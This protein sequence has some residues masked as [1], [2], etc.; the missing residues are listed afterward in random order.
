MSAGDASKS[1]RL[2]SR[3][4]RAISDGIRSFTVEKAFSVLIVKIDH[5]ANT[6]KYFANR[7]DR[8]S[9]SADDPD[10]LAE[11]MLKMCGVITT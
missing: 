3:I 9:V 11:R 2:I 6:G 8:V 4:S 5:D 1:A 10:Q 7:S